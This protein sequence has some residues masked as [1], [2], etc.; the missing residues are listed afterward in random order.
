MEEVMFRFLDSKRNV[1]AD[2]LFGF[3]TIFASFGQISR[4]NPVIIINFPGLYP[5]L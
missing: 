4:Q 5:G 2:F 3:V 1:G